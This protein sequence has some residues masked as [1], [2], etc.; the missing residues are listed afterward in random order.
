MDAIKLDRDQQRFVLTIDGSTCEL[1]FS[2]DGDLL[3][4][5]HVRVPKAVGGQG[6]AGQLTRHALDWA[7]VEGF[8]V[9][10]VC[11]YVASWIEKHPDYQDLV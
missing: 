10:P 7:R 3:S 6:I 5:N 9:R 4:L 8:K 2:H 11:P 1:G